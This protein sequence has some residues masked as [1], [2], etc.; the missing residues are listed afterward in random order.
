MRCPS[1]NAARR[2]ASSPPT[3]KRPSGISNGVTS[4]SPWAST[5]G[6]WCVPPTGWRSGSKAKR[7]TPSDGVGDRREHFRDVGAE[8]ADA[9]DDDKRDERRDQRIFESGDAAI[10][11]EQ[12]AQVLQH[13]SSVAAPV[14]AI[15]P[16]DGRDSEPVAAKED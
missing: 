8:Q 16:N 4:S 11:T 6:C 5:P 9:A 7:R 14:A 1:A 3:R 10:L 15:V 12:A 2:R 13:G